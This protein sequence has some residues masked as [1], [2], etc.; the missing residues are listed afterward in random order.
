MASHA[1]KYALAQ[2]LSAIS[3]GLLEYDY[4]AYLNGF[5]DTNPALASLAGNNIKRFIFAE[6]EMP[7][8]NDLQYGVL[9]EG[10]TQHLL[11]MF[12]G[13]NIPTN[14][15]NMFDMPGYFPVGWTIPNVGG[16]VHLSLIHI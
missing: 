10:M 12:G 3:G 15:N 2:G 16:A 9:N 4:K 13:N 6:C 11:R 1:W 14:M 8:P 5:K 7:D